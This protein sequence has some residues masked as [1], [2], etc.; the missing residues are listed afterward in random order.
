MFK[1]GCRMFLSILYLVFYSS[2]SDL[3][4]FQQRYKTRVVARNQAGIPTIIR[5]YDLA[6]NE[7]K[8]KNTI[9]IMVQKNM[10]GYIQ[11]INL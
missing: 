11:I 3:P 7:L 6:M 2:C 9:T 8:K 10:R 1:N 5:T 4:L